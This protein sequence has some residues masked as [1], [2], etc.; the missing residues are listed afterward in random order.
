MSTATRSLVALSLLCACKTDDDPGLEPLP[1]TTADPT[2]TTAVPTTDIP[3]TAVPTTAPEPGTTDA[4]TGGDSD[5]DSDSPG[6]ACVPQ[7]AWIRQFHSAPPTGHNAMALAAD[8]SGHALLAAA[9]EGAVDLGAGPL[10]QQDNL[11]DAYLARFA[12]DGTL[13]WDHH[14]G[15]EGNQRITTLATAP[16]DDILLGGYYWG[17]LALGGAPL[18]TSLQ[19]DGWLARLGPDGAPKWSQSFAGADF[20]ELVA[21]ASDAVGNTLLLAQSPT[22]LSLGGAPVDGPSGQ[23]AF[24]AGLD[25]QGVHV[26]SRTLGNGSLG[27]P[28]DPRSLTVDPT[29]AVAIAGSYTGS[30]DFGAGPLPADPER[31]LFVARYAS[32]GSFVFQRS[33]TGAA[34]GA[35]PE[36]A[37]VTTDAAGRVW[38]GGLFYGQLGMG[39]PLL[40]S[41]GMHDA[42]VLALDEAGAP[43]WGSRHGGDA[44]SYEVIAALA[45]EPG[46]R[47]AAVGSYDTAIDFGDLHLA[48]GPAGFITLFAPDGAVLWSLPARF[49]ITGALAE[50]AFDP[51]G[52]LYVAGYFRDTFTLADH[53]LAAVAEY[54]TVLI[55]ILTCPAPL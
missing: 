11:E 28:I 33:S 15:G 1:G 44:D 6:Q 26:W 2:T 5:S 48:P 51:A 27:D 29:G 7:V 4:T 16:G 32:D 38:L 10:V 8:S 53:D 46:G 43:R 18:P 30:V 52:D 17:E 39:G 24:V 14:L 40:A 12:P 25:P 47:V 31:R 9:F 36:V 3:T 42:F 45:A 35:V 55:K 49:G 23:K 37:G 50:V 20:D 34:T 21:V 54:D 22:A 41:D 19:R 13:V